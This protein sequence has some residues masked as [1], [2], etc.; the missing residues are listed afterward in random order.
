MSGLSSYSV[1][2]ESGILIQ[3]FRGPVNMDD[4]IAGWDSLFRRNIVNHNLSGIISDYTFASLEVEMKDLLSMKKFFLSNAKLLKNL[5]LA[6]VIDSPKIVLPQLFE[7][8]NPDFSTR[9]F[10]TL[11]AAKKW[12]LETGDDNSAD[13]SG[14][15]SF[16]AV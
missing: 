4:I 12:I 6:Q 10:S 15:T 9:A 8:E 3:H 14:S 1:E 2:K 5:R 16:P 11:D 7:N 13:K